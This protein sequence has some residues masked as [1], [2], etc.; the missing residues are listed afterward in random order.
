MIAGFVHHFQDLVQLRRQLKEATK[1][2]QDQS[3]Q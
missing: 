2:V 3:V 1:Y